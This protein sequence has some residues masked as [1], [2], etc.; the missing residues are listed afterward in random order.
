MHAAASLYRIAIGFGLAVLV[1]LAMGLAAFLSPL[2]RGIVEDALAVLNSTSVFVWIV[3][4]LI[5]F[6]LSSWAPI[7]TTFMITLP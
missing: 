3:I 7:F 1:S 4:S 5:W 6:G 2:L